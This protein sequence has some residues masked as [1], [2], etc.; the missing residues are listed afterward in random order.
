MCCKMKL[1]FTASLTVLASAAALLGGCSKAPAPM[2]MPPP[3]VSVVTAH[4]QQVPLTRDL[5]GR[6]SATR[7]ADV[8]AR[9]AGVL[10]KR[11]YTEGADVKQGE[12]LFQIDPMPL[13]ATLDA[14]RANLASAQATA[15]NAKA[16]ATRARALVPQN[17][18]SHNDLDN[19]L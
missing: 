7:S 10:L 13:K 17:Y 5:V 9:V 2:S 8:R 16:A 1:A 19:A 15:T 12:T 3:Q 11:V 6:L 18:I 4:A 14:Q